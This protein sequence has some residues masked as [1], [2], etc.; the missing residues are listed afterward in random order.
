MVGTDEVFLLGKFRAM[1]ELLTHMPEH[2]DGV[3]RFYKADE[4]E[5][6]KNIDSQETNLHKVR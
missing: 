1:R 3:V 2:G 6:T 4:H 5:T